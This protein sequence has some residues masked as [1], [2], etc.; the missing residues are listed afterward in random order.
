MSSIVMYVQR[1]LSTRYPQPVPF[2][3]P[4]ASEIH[5]LTPLYWMLQSV[6][7]PIEME[8]ACHVTPPS[9]VFRPSEEAPW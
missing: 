2:H 1:K 3:P 5:S 7:L 4:G 8:S 6:S 9:V